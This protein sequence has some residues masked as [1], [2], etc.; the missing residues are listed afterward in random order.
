MARTSR[1]AAIAFVLP[2]DAHKRGQASKIDAFG[3]FTKVGVWALPATRDFSLIVGIDRLPLGEST[4]A[5]WHRP[6]TGKFARLGHG[7]ITHRD[8]SAASS[9]VAHRVSL[10]IEA[11][12]SHRLVA[13]LGRGIPRPSGAGFN[14]WVHELPWPEVL[15]GTDLERAL[16]DPSTLKGGRA[17][18]ECDGCN[19]KYTFEVY[20]DPNTSLGKGSLP[21]PE[22]GVF[23]CPK[24]GSKHHV[25]DIE[26][27]IRNTLGRSASIGEPA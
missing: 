24:D 8:E 4:L 19:R 6:P 3:L 2:A 23:I 10:R 1:P 7:D 20:L 12:G 27:Q 17:V 11:A 5:I 15:S 18:L 22:S 16:A 13:G 9:I 14:L 21:F 26:G 25:R